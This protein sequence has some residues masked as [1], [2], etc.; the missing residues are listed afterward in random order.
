MTSHAPKI[1]FIGLGIMGKP[2]ARNLLAAGYELTVH[3]RSLGPVEEL[4]GAGAAVADNPA[5]VASAS[6]VVI[7]MLPDTSDVEM[8]VF[9]PDGLASSGRQRLLYIDMSTIDPSA[10]RRIAAALAERGISMLDAP[11]S[12]GERGAIDANLSIMIGGH[13]ADFRRA[14]PIFQ[15]LG[16][17]IVHVG[18][19]GAGQVTK[20]CNQLVV[21][22]NIEAVA[23]A[24]AL[25]KRA[26][27]DQGTVRQ[28]L[29]GGFAAS[30]VLEAH[31]T[32]M[33]EGGFQPGFRVRLHA[34]DARIVQS[35]AIATGASTPAFNVVAD[36]LDQLVRTGRGDLDHSALYALVS[37]DA[38][39]P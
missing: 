22:S 10:T 13:E 7:T 4:A 37:P 34:K 8:V 32:R 16:K 17:T 15:H 12:G 11:V 31:G 23:E 29:L 20:A 9:G 5:A 38:P 14:E 1:G 24:L 28:V 6:D 36:Q 18:E 19:V 2:M 39:T 26:G 35:L 21:G 3:S 27:V 25:A 33:I 30:R